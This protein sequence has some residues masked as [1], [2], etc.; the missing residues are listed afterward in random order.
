V[1]DP[2]LE[3]YVEDNKHV[4]DIVAAGYDESVVRRIITLVDRSEYKRRQTPLGPRVTDR[5]F[6]RDWRVP[7]TNRFSG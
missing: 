4:E 3:M 2:I 5:A 1:L 6:G 7:I